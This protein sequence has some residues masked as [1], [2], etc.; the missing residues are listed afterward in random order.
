[1]PGTGEMEEG[2]GVGAGVGG[3]GGAIGEA[4]GAGD[5]PMFSVPDEEV[6]VM[7]VET[8]EIEGLAGAFAGGA[9]GEFAEAADFAERDGDAGS[10]FEEDVE[11]AGGED[12]RK[13]GDFGAQ[14]VG[15]ERRSDG[16]V[17]RAEGEGIGAGAE[18]GGEP[19]GIGEAGDGEGFT[20]D[21]A[22]GA[23][24]FGEHLRG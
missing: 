4:V 14:R 22:D 12:G 13:R 8:V 6:G 5:F 10:G 15:G 20:D 11:G 9:E 16:G 21:E 17:A 18:E 23:A 24:A 2:G 3:E 7:G 1:M 19:N